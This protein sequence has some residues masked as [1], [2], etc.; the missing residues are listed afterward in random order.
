MDGGDFNGPCHMG[1]FP[2]I[3]Y[4]M[5]N[6][7]AR[8]RWIHTFIKFL[9]ASYKYNFGRLIFSSFMGYKR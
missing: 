1:L 2:T 3:W 4:M 6:L 8:H 7:E 5:V 9:V